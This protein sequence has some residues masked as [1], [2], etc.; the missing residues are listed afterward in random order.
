MIIKDIYLFKKNIKNI[1][2]LEVSDSFVGCLND[3]LTPLFKNQTGIHPSRK[4]DLGVSFLA[5]AKYGL[6]SLYKKD[7]ISGIVLDLYITEYTS[8]VFVLWESKT[9]CIYD[10]ND[11]E[12]NCSDIKFWFHELKPL[13]Y[14]KQL[15][16]NKIPVQFENLSYEL[17]LNQPGINISIEFLL[18]DEA[19]SKLETIVSQV[20]TYLREFFTENT[21]G[22]KNHIHNFKH[23]I[24]RKAVIFQIDTGITGIEFY[25]HFFSFLSELNSFVQVIV[26]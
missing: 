2:Q 14:Q 21:N 3:Q 26:S 8:E 24:E 11:T 5:P 22:T 16:K 6:N 7:V 19:K 15:N 13:L 25:K 10:I 9:G 17:I 1:Y 20:E 4:I 18:K 23:S 12:I